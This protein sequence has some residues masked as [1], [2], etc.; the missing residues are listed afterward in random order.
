MADDGTNAAGTLKTPDGR[1][2]AQKDAATAAGWSSIA[3]IR[4]DRL[5]NVLGQGK[6]VAPATLAADIQDCG[7]PVDVVELKKHDLA[8]TQS[9]AC[10]EQ[11]NGVIATTRGGALI[12][13]GQQ[14]IDL[15]G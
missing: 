14:L 6:L 3:Q 13:A 11:H 5:T 1:S 12:D 4:G 9:Q 8:G 15:I 2:G 10:Q 7:V